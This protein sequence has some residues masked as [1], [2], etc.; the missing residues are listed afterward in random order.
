VSALAGTTPSID[1]SSATKFTLTTSGAT[2]FAASSNIAAGAEAEIAI[3][4]GGAHN[5]SFPSWTWIGTA[6]PTAIANGKDMLIS[7]AC[8]GATEQS[9]LAGYAVE[10]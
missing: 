9:C 4:G 2:T 5:L 7:I 8:Y 6:A 10:P 3:T 1:F